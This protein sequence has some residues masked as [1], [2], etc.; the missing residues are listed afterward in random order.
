MAGV[1]AAFLNELDKLVKKKKI[2][3][4][5]LVATLCVI[6]G[7]IAVTL[8][9]N[10]FGLRVVGSLEF[11]IIVLSVFS[12][13]VL[14][15]FTAFVA[16]DMF[17]GEFTSNTMKITLSRPVSRFGVFTAKVLTIA[18]FIL[19]NL[20]FVMLLSTL[21]GILF[22]PS[23][24]SLSNFARV[25]MSY[26][27]TF[28]PIFTL[29]LLIVLLSNIFRNGLSVFFL[30]VIVFLGFNVLGILFSTYSSFFITS[31]LDWY[32]LWIS[33]SPGVF[34]ILRQFLIMA[35]CSIMFFTA[36]YYLF[37]KRDL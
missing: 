37:D 13:T 23:S 15:L 8:I 35:G 7:Q 25:S 16:I 22:N 3:A 4:A 17:C 20:L 12:Y 32:N 33:D 27:S 26:I 5:V 28:V 1:K 11:P 19:A 29:A 31:M 24:S 10:G 36:G 30:S 6:I 34:K 18:L 14:P 9:K 21:A 2:F